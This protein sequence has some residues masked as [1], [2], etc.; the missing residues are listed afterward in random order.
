MRSNRRISLRLL[1]YRYKKVILLL[2]VINH[3]FNQPGQMPDEQENPN[4]PPEQEEAANPIVTDS[5]VAL[6]QPQTT[7]MEVHHHPDV[8][9]K[10]LKEYLLEGLMI[11]LAVTMGFIA[12]NVREHI[13][14]H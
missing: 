14:E 3:L 8:E 5:S 4:Q 7:D 6:I 10:G 12:E 13:T 1:Y 9:K 2:P 11:F